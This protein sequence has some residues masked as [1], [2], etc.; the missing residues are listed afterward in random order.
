M[1]SGNDKAEKASKAAGCISGLLTGWGVPGAVARII[2]GA[3]IGAVA[4]YLA[5]SQS[6][7][8][9][10]YHQTAEGT[11]FDGVLVLPI[12]NSTTK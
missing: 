4:A 7:C 2:A 3:I 12:D 11:Y 1:D 9:A 5:L 10:S 8:T 6:G